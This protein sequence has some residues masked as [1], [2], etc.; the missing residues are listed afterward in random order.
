MNI[1]LLIFQK[2]IYLFLLLFSLS[3]FFLSTNSAFSKNLKIENIEI[4]KKFD[5]KFDRNKVIDEGFNLAFKEL[6]FMLVQ[7]HDRAK[8]KNITLEN[9]KILIEN[10]SIKEEKF[11]N[12]LYYVSLNVEFN[13]RKIFS[14]LEKKNVFPSLPNKKKVIF[15]PILIDEE[16]NDIIL[17]SESEIYNNWIKNNDKKDL[18]EYILPNEDL[19]DIS[20]IKENYYDL[21][22]YDFSD[23]LKKYSLKSYIISL[24]Y[25]NSKK[26]RVLSKVNLN[27]RLILD[28]QYFNNYNSEEELNDLIKTSK[29]RFN[30]LWKKENQI[31]TSIKLPLII[32]VDLND[33]KKINKFEKIVHEL[34]L[35]S[36]F[37]ISKIDNKKIYYTLVY[38]GTP[39]SFIKNIEN[40]GHEIDFKNKIWNFQ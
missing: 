13:K 23:I 15:I 22:D 38:N 25:K 18:L 11:L 4:S 9:I 20:V 34:E 1:K 32:A 33:N 37:F 35:V 26:I 2:Y 10:F 30:D 28:N 3:Y 21:E 16:I 7:S 14:L 12:D 36:S 40:S 5:E 39:K 29:I 27:N 31:N 24:F 8:I 17:F 19:E 6:I